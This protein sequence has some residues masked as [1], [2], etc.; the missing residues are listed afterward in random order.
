[1]TRLVVVLLLV[2]AGS[3]LRLAE[4][5]VVEGSCSLLLLEARVGVLLL[6]R[7]LLLEA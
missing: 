1:M 5:P 2:A 3:G 7:L 4:D 6:L